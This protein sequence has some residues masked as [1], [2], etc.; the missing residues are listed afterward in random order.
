[1]QYFLCL[2]VFFTPFVA[3]GQL[4]LKQPFEDCQI[5]GSITIYDYNRQEWIFSD[6]MDAR[7]AT[8][9]AS[10]FK[11]INSCIALET[12]TVK[13]EH[14]VF[15]WD[16]KERTVFGT[17]MAAWN[18]DTDLESAYKNST[19]WYYVA[20]AEKI[21]R[22][23]YAAYLSECHYGNGDLSEAGTDFWN[24]GDFAVSPINQ[25]EFLK[26][27]YEE[28]LTFSANTYAIVKKI[29][30]SEATDEYTI[31]D[32]TGWT[33]KNGEDIGWW[34]GYVERKENVYFFATRLIKPV[35]EVN[36]DFAKCRKEITK[37]ILA[38]IKAID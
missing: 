25:I 33:S 27:F 6:S 24:Y 30:V 3:L 19:I 18:K 26:D 20:L 1:M 8:L 4:D 34:I 12:G 21:G 15:K 14:V 22:E 2:L 36:E 11:I 17:P 35:N 7:R 32:K 23:K 29:M 16:G 13:D 10:T 38:Q 31:R 9:P 5:A 28:Q 37:R